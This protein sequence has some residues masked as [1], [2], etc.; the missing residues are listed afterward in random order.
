[1]SENPTVVL[2]HGAFVDGTGWKAVYD[3]LRADGTEVRAVQNPTQTLDGDVA[4]VHL[5]LDQLTGPVVLV[6]HSYGGV[7][8]TEAGNHETVAALVYVGAFAPDTGESVNSLLAGT[9]PDAPVPPIVPLSDQFV[10]LDRG[11]FPERFAADVPADLAAFMA[12]SQTPWGVA[13]LAG[14]ITDAAWHHKPS[15]FL[16]TGDDR[17]IPSAAQHGMAERAGATVTET[18]ASH[19][20]FLSRPGVVADVIRQAIAGIA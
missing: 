14:E 5:V 9:P 16:V 15:W 12:D 13:A 4:A 18:A 3:L 7:I 11:Q 8:I 19:S 1:M 10:A 20:V 17:M 2:V 6:G